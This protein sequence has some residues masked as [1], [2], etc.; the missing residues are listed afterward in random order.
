[1]VK[2]LLDGQGVVSK[3][4]D[5]YSGKDWTYSFR[6][7]H[8][9]AARM[10]SNIKRARAEMSV[11]TVNEFRNEF[12]NFCG[13]DIRPENIFN[14]DETNLTDDPGKKW[15]LVRR[16]RRR[17]EN[18]IDSSKTAIS[19]MWCGSATGEMCPPCVVYKAENTYEGWTT[20]APPGTHF[21]QSKR[22]WFNSETFEEWFMVVMLPILK[23]KEGRKGF[24][25]GQPGVPL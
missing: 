1:M 7:R 16:G 8:N 12:A 24:D 4:K 23:E 22:G 6:K 19:V 17:V 15:V 5:N 10:A 3:W 21:A 14:F 2:A 13:E 20:G 18:V 11:E 9:L 25:R